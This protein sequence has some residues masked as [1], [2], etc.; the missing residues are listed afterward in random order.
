MAIA[1]RYKYRAN[2]INKSTDAML[3]EGHLTELWGNINPIRSKLYI[4]KSVQP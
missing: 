1:D 2:N 4:D 3:S